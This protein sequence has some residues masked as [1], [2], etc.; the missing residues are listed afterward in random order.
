MTR[1]ITLKDIAQKAGISPAA[2]S[3][4]LNDK[5]SRISQAKKDEVK[6]IAKELNYIPNQIAKSLSTQQTYTIGLVVPDLENPF[7]ATL[8]KEVERFFTQRGYFTFIMNSDEKNNQDK[9][10]VQKMLQRQ[11]D[12]LLLCASNAAYYSLDQTNE[13]FKQITIPTVLVDRIFD[14]SLS[15]V[16]FDHFQGGYLVG[17]YMSQA[18]SPTKSS[19]A[20]LTGDLKTHTASERLKGFQHALRHHHKQVEP[21][22][23]SGDYS[24]ES[25]YQMGKELLKQMSSTQLAGVFC[26]NDLIA[27]GFIKAIK[28]EQLDWQDFGIVG[29]DN[30]QIGKTLGYSFPSI[31]QDVPYLAEQA[32]QVLL[33][34]INNN[35]TTKVKLEL[36]LVNIKESETTS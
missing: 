34:Q 9:E 36:E 35:R 19:I 16:A 11:V 25:G 6:R 33:K 15:S 3:I 27:Y 2:V 29:Y 24:I 17:E 10:I 14:S 8:S 31:A 20:C 30:L 23:L 7:F 4:I 21:L 32:C 5:P 28:E 12:G 13:W 26:F 1:K 22:I 18:L